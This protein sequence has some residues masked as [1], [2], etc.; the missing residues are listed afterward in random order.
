MGKGKKRRVRLG[1]WAALLLLLGVGLA[2]GSMWF[3]PEYDM[4]VPGES[5]RMC[6]SREA[7]R[8][9]SGVPDSTESSDVAGSTTLSY[10]DVRVF[11]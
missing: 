1:I 3:F 8:W 10:S 2:R 11:G 7:L 5:M 9:L 6:A 4:G